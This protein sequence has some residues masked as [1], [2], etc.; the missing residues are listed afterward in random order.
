MSLCVPSKGP[1]QGREAQGTIGT[2]WKLPSIG[3]RT[4]FVVAYSHDLSLR[5][6]PSRRRLQEFQ[7]DLVRI[8][9]VDRVPAL[10]DTRHDAVRL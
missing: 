9:E 4:D 3:E 6:E 10:V 7:D 1:H 5:R 2:S 8:V